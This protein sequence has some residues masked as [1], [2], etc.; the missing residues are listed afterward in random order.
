M[1]FLFWLG[2]RG[3]RNAVVRPNAFLRRKSAA[4]SACNAENIRKCNRHG[5]GAAA[6][7][8]HLSFHFLFSKNGRISSV[9]RPD[10]DLTQTGAK[11]R[12][13]IEIYLTKQ[14]KFLC[15]QEYFERLNG[16][17][18]LQPPLWFWGQIA[19]RMVFPI[20]SAALCFMPGVEWT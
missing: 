10:P 16:G 2:I 15:F 19:L 6:G 17:C 7:V 4:F 20:A 18:K 8:S 14:H 9:M 13:F 12:G 1:A 5:G 11:I 3:A